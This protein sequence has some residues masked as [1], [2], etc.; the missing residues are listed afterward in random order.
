MRLGLSLFIIEI[1]KGWSRAESRV[2]LLASK[3][4]LRS[5]VGIGLQIYERSPGYFEPFLIFFIV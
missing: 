4:N 1:D 2:K 5:K 3:T